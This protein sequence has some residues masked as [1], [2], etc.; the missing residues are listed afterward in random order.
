MFALYPKTEIKLFILEAGPGLFWVITCNSLQFC[1]F[2]DLI[3]LVLYFSVCKY[4]AGNAMHEN[5]IWKYH[6]FVHTPSGYLLRNC[7][8]N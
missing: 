5:L 8:F 1:Y 2:G 7:C 6:A 4:H 3:L